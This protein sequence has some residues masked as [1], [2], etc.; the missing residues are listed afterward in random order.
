M[1]I[2]QKEFRDEEYLRPREAFEKA[3]FM[4]R[5]ASGTPGDCTGKFGLKAKADMAVGALKARDFDAVAFIGG[6]G[7]KGFWDDAA[8]HAAARDALSLGRI[9]AAI[10]SAPVILAHAGLLDGKRATCFPGDA[11]ELR[12]CG[13]RY[14]GEAVTSDGLLIT[15][16]GPDAAAAFGDTIVKALA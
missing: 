12:K 7:C 15:G 2:A 13:A 6:A 3:G 9:V 11:E 16:N 8:C 4:V 5:V 10:C 14:T 1:V